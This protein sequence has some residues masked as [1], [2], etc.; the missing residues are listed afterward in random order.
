MRGVQASSKVYMSLSQSQYFRDKVGQ[1][2]LSLCSSALV[3]LVDM[4]PYLF[5]QA[6]VML[7][8]LM[9]LYVP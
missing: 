9:A 4:S 1:V 2:S 3:S 8:K 7:G 5:H 6:F